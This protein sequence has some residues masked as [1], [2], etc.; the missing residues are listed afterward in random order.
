M[1]VDISDVRPTGLG[2]M[3]ATTLPGHGY[4]L[5]RPLVAA[6]SERFREFLGAAD[7]DALNTLC[8]ALQV[9]IGL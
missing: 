5:G 2:V 6:G 1:A 3:L 4:I 9:L 8:S 7:P